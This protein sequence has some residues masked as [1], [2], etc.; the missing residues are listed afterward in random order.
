MGLWQEPVPSLHL[1]PCQWQ[2]ECSVGA[3]VRSEGLNALW[4]WGPGVNSLH[5]FWSLFFC[6]KATI[7]APS[8]C[9]WG[10]NGN[11]CDVAYAKYPV[12]CTHICTF[13]LQE[14]KKKKRPRVVALLPLGHWKNW[15][16]RI[17][18]CVLPPSFTSASTSSFFFLKVPS[19]VYWRVGR[20]CANFVWKMPASSAWVPSQ[21][22]AGDSVFVLHTHPLGSLLPGLVHCPWLALLPQTGKCYGEGPG[23][24]GDI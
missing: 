2:S 20:W 8:E 10:L 21:P 4:S 12:F 3:V 9:L 23:S 16:D 13:I 22:G 15:C 18:G 7:V 5:L 17:V 19:A 14:D 6:A 11:W 24:G 1:P